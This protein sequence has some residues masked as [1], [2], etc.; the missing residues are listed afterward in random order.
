MTAYL[1]VLGERALV[2][3]ASSLVALLGAGP[4]NVLEVPW[5]NALATSAGAALLAILASV[6]AGGI[7]SSDSPAFTSKVTELEVESSSNKPGANG[8]F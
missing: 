4:L 7:T 1:K 8:A 3:F 6:A 5:E 2:A